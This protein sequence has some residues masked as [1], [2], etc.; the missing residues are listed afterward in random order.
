ME[1]HVDS[2]AQKNEPEL[3]FEPGRP[4]HCPPED[5]DEAMGDGRGESDWA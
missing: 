5:V 3:R 4:C 1:K 2:R